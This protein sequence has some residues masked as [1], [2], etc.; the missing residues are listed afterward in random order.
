MTAEHAKLWLSENHYGELFERSSLPELLAAYAAHVTEALR[1]ELAT[2][3]DAGREWTAE[4][5]QLELRIEKDAER[6]E[7]LTLERT[8]LLKRLGKPRC[9]DCNA[10]GIT[11]CSHFNNCAGTW[12]YALEE[13]ADKAEAE[14]ERLKKA[15]APNLES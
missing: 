2:F 14:V 5:G 7:A 12:K 13:R 9:L 11:N 3:K 1:K 4:R 10:V 6:V 8:E 15:I